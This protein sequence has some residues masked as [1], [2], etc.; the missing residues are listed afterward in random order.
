MKVR[1]LQFWKTY[2]KMIAAILALPVWLL[3]SLILPKGD[4]FSIALIV[5][6]FVVLPCYPVIYGVKTCKAYGMCW[7][8][9]LLLLI[10]TWLIIMPFFQGSYF[11]YSFYLPMAYYVLAQ[12]SA[13]ITSL[14]LKLR[15]RQADKNSELSL[16]QKDDSNNSKYMAHIDACEDNKNDMP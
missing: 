2:W 15:K 8:P 6:V 13:L 9:S 3:L 12:T 11:I 4:M 16:Y 1:I 5:N 10:F 14:V 7:S